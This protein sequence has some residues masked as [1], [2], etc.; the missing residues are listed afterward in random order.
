MQ[1]KIKRDLKMLCPALL[2]FVF[3]IKK[4]LHFLGELSN[5]VSHTSKIYRDTFSMSFAK[6]GK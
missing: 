2:G 3:R 5:S 6:G 4:Q 1:F